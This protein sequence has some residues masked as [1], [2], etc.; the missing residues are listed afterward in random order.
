MFDSLDSDAK[1]RYELQAA[2]LNEKL[3]CPPDA[4]EIYVYVMFATRNY[5]VNNNMSSTATKLALYP[6]FR[7][8]FC[9]CLGGTGASA[10]PWSVLYKLHIVMRKSKSKS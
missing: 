6:R 10:D 3:D 5:H 7:M 1:A 8:L 4:K 2:A 9:H